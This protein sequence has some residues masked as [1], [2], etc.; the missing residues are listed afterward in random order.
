[1]QQSNR[2]TFL[3]QASLLSATAVLPSFQWLSNQNHAFKMSLNTGSIGLE[4]NQLE[5]M[6]LATEYGFNA[7]TV[8]LNEMINMDKSERMDFVEQMKSKGISWGSTNLP[9]EFRASEKTFKK[10]LN[11]LPRKAEVLQEIGG[12]RMNTWI[13]P[14]HKTLTYIENF[15]QHQERLQ[16]VA[17]VL[18]HYD[19]RLGLEYVGP[20]TLMT[21]DRFSF[22]H[23]MQELKM[24]MDA[25]DESNVGF[26]LDS[27]HWFCAEESV[28][29][30]LTLDKEDIVTV[31]LN[32]ATAG[33]NAAEQIDNERNLPL[34]SG[35]ID[36]KAFLSALARIGYDGPIR[37]EPFNNALNEMDNEAAIQA[38]A[39]AMKKAFALI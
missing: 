34:V 3:Q 19:I 7:M 2:R 14:T 30:L 38:T 18:G 24:L 21:R 11:E 35:V 22:I 16:Q 1:M 8:H 12:T 4:V 10:A 36:T 15:E 32:D 28:A 17:N 37:A 25:I 9:M 20:K 13:M 26:V 39:D 27:F 29:D 5:A 33:R 6:K 31:D 23:T